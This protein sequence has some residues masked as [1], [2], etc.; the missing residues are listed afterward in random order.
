MSET[1]NLQLDRNSSY[2]GVNKVVIP[3]GTTIQG[4]S[5]TDGSGSIP[6]RSCLIK[7]DSGN[8]GTVYI[9]IGS[10][11]TTD[12]WIVATG[13]EPI[14]IDDLNKLYFKGTAADVVRIIYR[15]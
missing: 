9:N 3:V 15:G 14:P 2:G 4:G 12:S 6:C 13:A 10:A 7:A 1:R 11:A 5:G 8:A